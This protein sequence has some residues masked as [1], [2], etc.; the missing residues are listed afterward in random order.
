MNR[1]LAPCLKGIGSTPPNSRLGRPRIHQR[2]PSLP[3][4]GTPVHPYTYRPSLPRSKSPTSAS[5]CS[6]EFVPM[7]DSSSALISIALPE[8]REICGLYGPCT[9]FEIQ[10]RATGGCQN[11]NRVRT[12]MHCS[13]SLVRRLRPGA[14]SQGERRGHPLRLETFPYIGSTPAREAFG[15]SG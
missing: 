8:K 12:T 11:R 6:S 9:A 15:S 13:P 3:L 5:T 7:L 1:R 14:T 4:T 2:T 10:S